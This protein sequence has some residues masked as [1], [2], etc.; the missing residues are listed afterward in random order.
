[1]VCRFRS[2]GIVFIL[3]SNVLLTQCAREAPEQFEKKLPRL[4][5]AEFFNGE[6]KAQGIATNFFEGTTRRFSAELRGRWQDD[7]I[8]LNEVWNWDDGEIQPRD[9]QWI[10]LSANE[11]LGKAHDVVEDARG[12]AVGNTVHWDYSMSVKTDSLGEIE[13]TMD[14]TMYLL[15]EKNI[16]NRIDMSK[17]GIPVGEVI[18]YISKME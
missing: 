8:L 4:D 12:K 18:I 11:W 9:W 6:I 1:M 15:D 17:F 3:I 13:I 14:D 10:K 16:L 2:L 5:L 7:R